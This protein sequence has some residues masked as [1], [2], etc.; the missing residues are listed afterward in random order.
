MRRFYVISSS[1]DKEEEEN[2]QPSTRNVMITQTN[3]HEDLFQDD[4]CM[5]KFTFDEL[6]STRRLQSEHVQ[7]CTETNVMKE[8]IE[9]GNLDNMT[10]IWESNRIGKSMKMWTGI[11]H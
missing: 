1:D 5:L 2:E 6:R 3:E 10:W 9:K 7:H 4:F 11:L 8:A